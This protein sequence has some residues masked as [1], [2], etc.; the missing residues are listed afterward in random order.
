[1]KRNVLTK[2]AFKNNF[3]W[4]NPEMYRQFNL[5]DM[6]MSNGRKKVQNEYP[7]GHEWNYQIRPLLLTIV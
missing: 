7:E 6:R 3:N 4:N 2:T 5:I 1:M